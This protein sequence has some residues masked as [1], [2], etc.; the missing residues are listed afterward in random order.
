MAETLYSWGLQ[1]TYYE[2]KGGYCEEKGG[3]CEEK[4]EKTT[5]KVYLITCSLVYYS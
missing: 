1:N 3:Y 5:L 2:E 4:G